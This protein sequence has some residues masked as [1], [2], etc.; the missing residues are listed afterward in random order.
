MAWQGTATLQ[1][2]MTKWHGRAFDVTNWHDEQW[3][4]LQIRRTSQPYDFDTFQSSQKVIFNFTLW[5]HP[6][7]NHSFCF[8]NFVSKHSNAQQSTSKQLCQH[9]WQSPFQLSTIFAD[10]T[11]VWSSHQ[12]L[13]NV[14]ILVFTF[15]VLVRVKSTVTFVYV[16]TTILK[17]STL[18]LRLL[19]ISKVS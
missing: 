3:S 11:I 19:I 5:N 15:A 12:R 13:I 1:L 6:S 8:G 18:L 10:S 16:W 7:S 9:S 17:E 2:G 14:G 4:S